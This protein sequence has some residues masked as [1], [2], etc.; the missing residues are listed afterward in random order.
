MDE[1]PQ[2]DYHVWYW[3]RN[4][5]HV[6]WWMNRPRAITTCGTGSGTRWWMDRPRA[7][8]TCGTGSGTT[9]THGYVD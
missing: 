2:G 7:I 9:T 1:S 3:S 5:Y 6:W 4:D 8:T